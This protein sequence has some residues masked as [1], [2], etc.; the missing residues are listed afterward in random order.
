MPLL[1]GAHSFFDCSFQLAD[2]ARIDALPIAKAKE[3]LG[4]FFRL[5]QNLYEE[6][7]VAEKKKKLHRRELEVMAEAK[8]L[9]KAANDVLLV[10][11]SKYSEQQKGKMNSSVAMA[12]L[13]LSS[14]KRPLL[15]IIQCRFS[16][17]HL[18]RF[19]QHRAFDRGPE[20]SFGQLLEVSYEYCSNERR[21][22]FLDASLPSVISTSRHFALSESFV[23][24]C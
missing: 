15:Q 9:Y 16:W 12:S 22:S 13:S 20:S 4:V 24:I 3:A 2:D 1:L 23:S 17:L 8:R 18:S 5:T 6:L 11:F 19:S 21:S 14:L 10:K 7:M